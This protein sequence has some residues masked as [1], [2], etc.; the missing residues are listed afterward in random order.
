MNRIDRLK[1]V[2]NGFYNKLETGGIN[3]LSNAVSA[4][5]ENGCVDDQHTGK[6]EE[7]NGET[8]KARLM[9]IEWYCGQLINIYNKNALFAV[10][11]W[12]NCKE[13]FCD[14]V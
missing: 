11:S 9:T 2:V 4:L 10:N 1:L 14:N 8:Y 12:L 13:K 6:G 7:M 5:I 3:E